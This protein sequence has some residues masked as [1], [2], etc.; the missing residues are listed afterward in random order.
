MNDEQYNRESVLKFFD[1][2]GI[3]IVCKYPRGFKK[4]DNKNYFENKII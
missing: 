3:D 4:E 1:E 2:K